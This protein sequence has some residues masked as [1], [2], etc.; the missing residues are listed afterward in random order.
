MLR[1]S[2]VW[3][4]TASKNWLRAIPLELDVDSH[5]SSHFIMRQ[6]LRA[7]EISL[8]RFIAERIP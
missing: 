3:A 7:P 8:V 6:N 5:G 1:R 2:L 4:K